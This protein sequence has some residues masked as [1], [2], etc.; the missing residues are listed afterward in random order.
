MPIT[1]T[2]SHSESQGDLIL[3]TMGPASGSYDVEWASTEAGVVTGYEPGLVLAG[4]SVI[5]K[6]TISFSGDL[7]NLVVPLPED[8]WSAFKFVPNWCLGFDASAATY[9]G[10]TCNALND[11]GDRQLDI[12]FIDGTDFA[13]GDSVILGGSYLRA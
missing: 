10:A 4:D 9:K 7:N 8:L 11:S 2:Q 1:I 3:Y 5:L 6:G 13:A 12:Y